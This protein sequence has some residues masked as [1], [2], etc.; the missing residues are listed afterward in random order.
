MLNVQERREHTLYRV[1]FHSC[2][3][4][5]CTSLTSLACSSW[6]ICRSRRCRRWKA[7]PLLKRLSGQ[8][9]LEI[10]C[11]L[12]RSIRVAHCDVQPVR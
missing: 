12:E 4:C 6:L 8:L 1:W 10:E 9:L 7:V 11:L 2:A 5:P 3:S